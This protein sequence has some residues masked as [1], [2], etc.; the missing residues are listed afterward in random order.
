MPHR[1]GAVCGSVPSP[2]PAVFPGPLSTSWS[3]AACVTLSLGSVGRVDTVT[4][5][6]LL[7]MEPHT[8]SF[9]QAQFSVAFWN[10][11]PRVYPLLSVFPHNLCGLDAVVNGILFYFLKKIL[12]IYF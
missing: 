1:P 5:L 7:L 2:G 11:Q 9:V 12:F 3:A 4:A 10:V 6:S 8:T